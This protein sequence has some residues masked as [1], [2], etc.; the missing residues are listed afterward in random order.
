VPETVVF[1][2]DIAV[3]GGVFGVTRNLQREFGAER[4]FDTPIAESAIL[5][6][7]LGASLAGLRPIV[8]IMW[9]DF[10][11]VALDQ[12]INQAANVRYLARGE[13]GAPMVVRTQQGAT[14]GSCAQ[15]CQSLEALLA[16][17]P[18]LRVALP[19]TPQDAYDAVLAAVDCDDPVI[20]I[21]SRKLYPKEGPVE[22]GVPVEPG[23]ARVYG[24]GRDLVLVTWGTAL[25]ACLDAAEQVRD[26]GADAAVVDLRW[27]SPLDLD[28]VGSVLARSGRAIVVHEANAT[29]GFGAEIV[30]R[31]V[32]RFWDSLE[33][34]PRRV[35]TPDVRIPASPVLQAAL[36]PSSER[37]V[38]AARDVL[39]H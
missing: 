21:E 30:A 32:E 17:V 37:I 33:T 29:G 8:E 13:L 38:T 7:A 24:E 39:A 16:H 15:H 23:T 2:E 27:L 35:A 10:L 12:L 34:P 28:T 1:G 26:E 25:G 4:V 18:G 14:P 11:L 20:V 9:S 31:L 6:S 19:A 22:R 3:P 36:L 5:G